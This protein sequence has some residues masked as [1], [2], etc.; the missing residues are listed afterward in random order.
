MKPWCLGGSNNYSIS[1]EALR[2]E[3]TSEPGLNRSFQ[4]VPSS[5]QIQG[6]FTC[7]IDGRKR[8]LEWTDG[9]VYDS[10]AQPLGLHLPLEFI[11]LVVLEHDNH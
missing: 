7:C 10:T 2:V 3:N 1:N 11:E 5:S 9:F 4:V 6:N 8:D